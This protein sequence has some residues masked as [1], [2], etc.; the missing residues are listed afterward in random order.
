MYTTHN[1]EDEVIRKNNSSSRSQRYISKNPN[2]FE[3]SPMKDEDK[4]SK[5]E[6]KKN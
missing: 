6:S 2:M 3:D 5:S 4:N 1:D